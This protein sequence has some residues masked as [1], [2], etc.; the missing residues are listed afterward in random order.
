MSFGTYLYE[1]R[2]LMS[3][4]R[5]QNKFRFK[6]RSIAEH[7]WSVSRIAMGL[8]LWQME[9]SSVTIDMGDLLQRTLLHDSIKLFAGDVQSSKKN[10]EMISGA[11]QEVKE[12]LYDSNFKQILPEDW[13]EPFKKYVLY[14]QDDTVEGRIVYVSN[15]IDALLES[16]EEVEMGNSRFFS[17]ILKENTEALIKANIDVAQWFVAY[18]LQ[19]L[20]LRD[21]KLYYGTDVDNFI[22]TYRRN[23]GLNFSIYEN[24]FGVY[25]TAVRDLMQ[26]MRYQNLYRHK[27]I[28]VAEHEWAVSR[29]AMG[30][31][32]LE[33]DKFGNPVDMYDLLSTTLVHDT[34]E[35][36]VGDVLSNVKR[37]TP[38]MLEAVEM[39]EKEA[40]D[41]EIAEIL[42]TTWHKEFR[43]KMLYPKSDTIEGQIVS[44]SDVIDTVLECMEEINLGN[45]EHFTEILD[46]SV[47]KLSASELES[48]K[49]FLAHSMADFELKNK[50]DGK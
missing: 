16:I 50:G 30:L 14:A 18:C 1:T 19:D 7:E 21:I 34:P 38:R 42:P 25:L 9:Y 8:A 44:A 47:S 35:F 20:G 24:T 43:R 11:L 15:I 23:N 41:N 39:R 4:K 29:I 28:S 6:P 36:I 31:A 45:P 10:K 5:Y 32:Y 17:D 40:F 37:I 46:R 33:R 2:R 27:S 13:R 49:Y 12:I 48:V 22:K 26:T 3:I